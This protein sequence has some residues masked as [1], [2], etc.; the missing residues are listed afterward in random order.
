MKSKTEAKLKQFHL[1]PDEALIGIDV[2]C[3]LLDRSR[4]SIWRDVKSKRCPAPVKIGTRCT[5]WRVGDL[6]KAVLNA[7]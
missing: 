4:A 5:R 6:R 7:A 1:L 2:L 3:A